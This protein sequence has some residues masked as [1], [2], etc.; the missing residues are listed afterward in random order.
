M[1][2]LG[3]VNLMCDVNTL[4][5][6]EATR[7]LEWVKQ[8]IKEV[9]QENMDQLEECS[10]C[11]REASTFCLLQ[12]RHDLL[13][14]RIQNINMEVTAHVNDVVSQVELSDAEQVSVYDFSKSAY[15]VVRFFA[16]YGAF[17]EGEEMENLLLEINFQS[18]EEVKL[19]YNRLTS[20][21]KSSKYLDEI[22]SHVTQIVLRNRN[23]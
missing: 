7:Q 10:E 2:A 23:A 8:R 15:E 4:S 9:Y 13:F 16:K 17:T 18:I 5:Y 21:V 20:G 6:F 19:F 14:E 22:I 1:A 12:D 3:R 11:K